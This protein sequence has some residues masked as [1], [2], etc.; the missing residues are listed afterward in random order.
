MSRTQ[1]RTIA[2]SATLL[3]VIVL[4]FLKG[5]PPRR[6]TPIGGEITNLSNSSANAATA[7]GMTTG[8]TAGTSSASN[9]TSRTD[10]P[11]VEPATMLKALQK[12]VKARDDKDVAILDAKTIVDIRGKPTAMNVI[13]T[14]R[15]DGPRADQLLEALTSVNMREQRLREQL[16]TAHKNQDVQAVNLLVAEIAQQRTSFIATNEFISYKISLSKDK[17]PV[18]SFWPGLPFETVREDAARKLAVAALGGAVDLQCLMQYTS[19]TALLCFT[20]GSGG[21]ICVDPFLMAEVP[22][23]GVQS[24]GNRKSRDTSGREDRVR[25]QW[26]EFLRDVDA[27]TKQSPSEGNSI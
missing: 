9:A 27:T 7:I 5:L 15:P 12:W 24:S 2:I 25:T 14:T 23:P 11:S 19:V 4:L 22:H 20:N 17:P 26:A 1:N 18:L 6:H 3:V 13:V 16:Q 21:R 10:E 8:Y